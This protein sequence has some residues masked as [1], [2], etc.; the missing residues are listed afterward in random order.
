MK[1]ILVPTD[2]SDCANNALSNAI[3]LAKQLQAELWL[4]NAFHVP[5]PHIEIGSAL[6]QPL[7]EGYEQNLEEDFRQ[8]HMRFPELDDMPTR[9]LIRHNFP[10][11]AI[12]SV[13]VKNDID[14]VVMGTRGATGISGSL[15]GSNTWAVMKDTR[16]PVLAVPQ[17]ANIDGLRN[18][19]F[20]C[21]YQHIRDRTIL[22]PLISLAKLFNAQ[23]HI[24]HIEHV[25]PKD[26]D[27]HIDKLCESV[28]IEQ[29]FAQVR[30]TYHLATV[31]NTEAGIADYVTA[32]NIDMLAP[33][34]HSFFDKLFK[35]SLTR[36][37]AFQTKIPLLTMHE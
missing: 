12:L 7:A 9:T 29:Y 16:C 10:T 17:N 11:D 27:K 37:M 3:K 5:V 14:L 8:L 35:G 30:H 24:L 1:R 34:K 13:I 23:V 18:I 31:H 6:V 19:V 33:R 36:K 21:D 22:E 32:N 26:K 2:F 20:A 28:N 25:P 4:L 15:L